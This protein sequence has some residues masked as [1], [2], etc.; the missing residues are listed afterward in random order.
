MLYD[1]SGIDVFHLYWALPI[2]R[3]GGQPSLHYLPILESNEKEDGNMSFEEIIGL[4]MFLV[5][6]AD[7]IRNLDKDDKQK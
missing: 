1:I 6:F 2:T 4:L 5:V 3:I 7:F